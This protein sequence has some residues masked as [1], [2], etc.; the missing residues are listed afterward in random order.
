MNK[1]TAT[2]KVSNFQA[3]GGNGLRSHYLAT[4]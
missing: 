1:N 2:V 4:S 3:V